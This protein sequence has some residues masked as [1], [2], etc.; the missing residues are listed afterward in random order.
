VSDDDGAAAGKVTVVIATRDRRAE[1]CRTL[2]H[3]A[4]LPERPPVVVVDNNSRDGTPAMVRDRHPAVRVVSLR[5]NVAAAA[6]NAGVLRAA[7]PYVAFSDDDSWWE[8]GSLPAAAGVLNAHPRLGLIAASVLVGEQAQ[9]DPINAMLAASPLPRGTLP[10][11][12]V[13]GFLACGSVVRRDAFLAVGGFSPLLFIGGEEELLAYDLAAAGWAAAY[14]PDVV[15]HHHPSA[16]RDP[17]RRRYLQ[18]RNRALV[19]WLRRPARA[20]LA[21]TAELARSARREPAAVRALSGLLLR[22]PYLIAGRRP[23]PPDVEAGI[24]LLETGH[25]G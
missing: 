4:E 11:P 1:L 22:A 2:D 21:V 5:R 15:A 17:A 3:L 18:A 23:L 25:A 9:P 10:G 8:P 16:V 13:L 6:R 24:R 7:T 14:L 19:A 20:A 12:R